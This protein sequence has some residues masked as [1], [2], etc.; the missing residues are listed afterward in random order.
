MVTA[1]LGDE[2]LGVAVELRAVGIGRLVARNGVGV[3]KRVPPWFGVVADAEPS[4]VRHRQPTHSPLV[5]V[6]VALS[7]VGIG[8]A[9]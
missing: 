4:R 3:G 7:V 9:N 1:V 8:P 5:E 2:T 6:L